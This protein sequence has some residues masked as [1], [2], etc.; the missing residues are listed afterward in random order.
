MAKITN[1]ALI[2]N[3]LERLIALA[4]TTREKIAGELLKGNGAAEYQLRW[5]QDT[6]KTVLQA[7]LAEFALSDCLDKA[8]VHV[9]AQLAC[10]RPNR[11]TNAFSNACNDEAYEAYKDFL[12]DFE[13]YVDPKRD[14]Q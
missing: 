3:K 9:K 1:E 7:R 6:Y 13:F 10:W 5:M 8:I 2:K 12:R 14:Q 4:N 11:S